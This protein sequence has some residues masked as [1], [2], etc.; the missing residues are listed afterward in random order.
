MSK[1][2]AKVGSAI[3][4]AAFVAGSKLVLG[5]LLLA[6]FPACFAGAMAFGERVKGF[7]ALL[8]LPPLCLTGGSM[9]LLQADGLKL[10]R[11]GFI[12]PVQ[13]FLE[14]APF[15]LPQP[16]LGSFPEAGGVFLPILQQHFE[17]LLGVTFGR[18]QTSERLCC[19]VVT[20]AHQI[21]H[22][23]QGERFGHA[24]FSD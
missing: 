24:E 22:H 8:L 2:R 19:L 5:L 11:D 14:I 18:Q 17:L 3:F 6:R 7:Q 16:I 15:G 9:R 12:E 1:H 20:I 23:L 13:E 10:L 21:E 4:L